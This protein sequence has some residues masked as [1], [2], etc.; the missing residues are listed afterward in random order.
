MLDILYKHAGITEIPKPVCKH[1][2]DDESDDEEVDIFS[3]Q[4]W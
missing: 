3:I 2:H 4:K 1:D